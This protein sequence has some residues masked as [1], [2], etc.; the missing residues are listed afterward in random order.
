MNRDRVVMVGAGAATGSGYV[1]GPRLVL[2]SAHVVGPVGTGV[3]LLHPGRAP[4]YR[5]AVVWSGT[6]GGSDDAALIHVDD[7]G[8][9]APAGR[10]EPW[11][12]L[13][14]R[15][16]RQPCQTWGVPKVSEIVSAGLPERPAT[17]ELK[18][19]SGWID[20]GSGLVHNRLVMA[21]EQTPPTWTP[22]TRAGSPWSGL[23]GA[24]LLCGGRGGGG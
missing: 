16:P 11:G 10:V 14:T 8:W 1:V 12:R 9:Q 18:Q 6:P 19:L 13:G 3:Q 20:P 23:S 22:S 7:P 17:P 24:A 5:A 15:I 2:T 4:V 21:L